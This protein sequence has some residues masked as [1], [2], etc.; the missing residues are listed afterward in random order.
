ML[1]LSTASTPPLVRITVSAPPITEKTVANRF[2]L[3]SLQLTFLN[4][5]VSNTVR[6][7]K[8]KIN[9]ANNYSSYILSHA[10]RK[11][12]PFL[13]ARKLPLFVTKLNARPSYL[14]LYHPLESPAI[15]SV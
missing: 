1:A 14:S 5:E 9:Q 3:L 4:N 10:I 15:V 7:T 12:P 8:P 13:R 11:V 6:T 2:L